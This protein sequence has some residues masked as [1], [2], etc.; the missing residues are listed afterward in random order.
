MYRPTTKNEWW[1]CGTLLLQALLVIIL[2]IFILVQWQSWVNPNIIQ[3]TPS[4]V[5]PVGMGIV[6]FA[7]I[8]EVI[9]SINAIHH[10]N[11]ISLLAV[12]L[13]NVC[14]VVY[15]VMQY[16][17]MREV[18]DSLQGTADGMGNPLV[19]WSRD[20]WPSMRPAE[21]AIPAVLTISSL[22][23][24]PAAYRLHKDYA[25]A[26]YKRIHGSPELRLRYLAYEIYLVLIKFDFFFLTGFIIQYDL[27]DVHFA[28]PE[29]S[30]TMA[31][32][33]A[34]LLVMVA[35]IYCVKSGLRVAMMVVI[36]C[37]LGSIAYL[38]SRIVVLCG[39]SQRAH[40]V[41]REMM[42][43]FAVVALVLIV[44][45]VGCA[46]QCIFNLSYGLQVGRPDS[47]WP[48]SSHAFQTLDAPMS[49]SI[50]DTRYHRRLSLD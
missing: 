21:F 20:I 12:C 15:A 31:L 26:I 33:P 41:G 45:T 22:V 42:L 1:F 47:R 49:P 50:Q 34:S 48:Q 35:G 30:L 23:I 24:I 36:V 3:I 28:E 9:L 43:F 11:N 37:F 18:T 19:D 25:W 39:N 40:T 27:I 2:E 5:V 46:V 44:M 13:T 4:Y 38:L 8:Y 32:I 17:K 29:Y 7:C 6:V 16:I 14:I 10:N